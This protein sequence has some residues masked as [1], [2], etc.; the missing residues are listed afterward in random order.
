MRKFKYN[1]VISLRIT[2]TN[3]YKIYIFFL[4]I[5]LSIIALTPIFKPIIINKKKQNYDNK[6]LA[7]YYSWYGNETDYTNESLGIEDPTKD[8]W[9]HWNSNNFDNPKPDKYAGTNTPK[10]GLYDSNDPNLIKYHF[11]LAEQAKID[12]FI[13]TWWGID[14]PTDVAF[15]NILTIARNLDTTIKLTIYF[16]TNQERFKS[17]SE[18]EVIS[19][20]SSEIKYLL[21]NYGD[22]SYFLKI[23]RKPVIFF[24]TTYL[25]SFFTWQ[26]IISNVK[27][28]Y[29]CF[30]IADIFP[31]PEIRT[32]ILSL[33]D[34]IHI[35]NPTLII[36]EQRK[37]S[38]DKSTLGS[39]GNIYQS[40]L[41]IANSFNKLCALTTIPGYD[42]RTIREPG[43]EISRN[44]GET[45][46]FLWK[47]SKD[48]DWVLITSFN[49]WHEGTEIEPSTQYNDYFIT[50]TEYWAEKF[51]EI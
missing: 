3:N 14:D 8:N 20:I 13:C 2:R 45:Y 5:I 39:I 17:S 22:N 11:N 16:E 10:Y 33:F 25:Y 29:D 36:S 51:K 15:K 49:E 42:D 7:F 9:F 35:Y 21:E 23:N 24:Y 28:E 37:I 6:I 12:G 47:K 4:I 27:S 48:A 44:D 40:M 30:L 1:I 43:I 32:E 50:R 38:I 34:G 26:K 19:T 18:A 41:K 31:L 46:D